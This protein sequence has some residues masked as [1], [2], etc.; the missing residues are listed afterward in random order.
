MVGV[1]KAQSIQSSTLTV[2]ASGLSVAWEV[3]SHEEAALGQVAP[4]GIREGIQLG[5]LPT[6]H[7]AT[8]YTY[9]YVDYTPYI[10]IQYTFTFAHYTHY[11]IHM[12]ICDTYKSVS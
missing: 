7:L 11:T 8:N 3:G 6:V 1:D 2:W 5:L 4:A 9:I 12:A 10:C